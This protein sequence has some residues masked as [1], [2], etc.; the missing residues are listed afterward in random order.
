MRFTNPRRYAEVGD[1]PS[2]R[3]RTV[4]AFDIETDGRG[5]E[6]VR[7][8]TKHP[9]RGTWSKHK[10]L[11]YGRKACIVDGD[12]DRIYALVLAKEFAQITIVAGTMV[13]LECVHQSAEPDRFAELMALIDL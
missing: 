5:Y 12:D 10:S 7:R 4:A 8:R 3:H 1:W 13:H 11:T 9:I 6:R 2:G